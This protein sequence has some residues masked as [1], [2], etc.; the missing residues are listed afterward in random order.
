MLKRPTSFANKCQRKMPILSRVVYVGQLRRPGHVS[1]Y[2]GQG[3]I[4]SCARQN[5]WQK[6]HCIGNLIFGRNM[7]VSGIKDIAAPCINI[8]P[9]RV[10]VDPIRSILDL[11]VSVQEQQVAAMPHENLRF[12][13]LIKNCTN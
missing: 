6:G 1:G 8:I 5:V 11:L 12:R 2:A 4:G 9:V 10:K 7:A 13:R 3:C